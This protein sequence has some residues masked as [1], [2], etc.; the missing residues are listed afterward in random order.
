MPAVGIRVD[1]GEF[2][3]AIA[4]IAIAQAVGAAYLVEPISVCGRAVEKHPG[5]VR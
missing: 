1:A 3:I 2:A 5:R 4:L